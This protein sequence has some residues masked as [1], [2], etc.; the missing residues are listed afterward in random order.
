MKFWTKIKSFFMGSVSATGKEATVPTNRKQ[1]RA[2]AAI[3]RKRRKRDS[4]SRS[5]A[6]P[7][8]K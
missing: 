3:E 2:Y 1:R 6:R 8:G 5:K 4:V 7:T